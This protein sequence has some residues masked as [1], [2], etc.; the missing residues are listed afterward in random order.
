MGEQ[1]EKEFTYLKGIELPAN[2]ISPT[3]KRELKKALFEYRKTNKETMLD[4]VLSG[5]Q[6]AIVTLGHILTSRQPVWRTSLVIA[7]LALVV[8]LSMILPPLIGQDK[9][10]IATDEITQILRS[11]NQ[12]RALLDQGATWHLMEK[13]SKQRFERSLDYHINKLQ[14][15]EG[16]KIIG[17]EIN[18]TI[19]ANRML[20]E[21]VLENE[22]YYADVDIKNGEVLAFG[23]KGDPD[24]RAIDPRLDIY[25][26]GIFYLEG[27]REAPFGASMIVTRGFEGIESYI[28]PFYADTLFYYP[29]FD[30]PDITTPPILE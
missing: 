19:I 6:G 14:E 21:L 2:T 7:V 8:S 12:T 3:H 1:N 23:Q 11:D 29:S 24:L 20:V 25:Y 15:E 5:F 13:D 16:H 28:D 9:E 10:V 22:Y 18:L 4:A 17:Q 30:I 27:G 26:E